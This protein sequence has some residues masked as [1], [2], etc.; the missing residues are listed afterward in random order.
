MELNSIAH[1][2]YE[3]LSKS[4]RSAQDHG[5]LPN[6]V[7]PP[8][9]LLELESDRTVRLVSGLTE[10]LVAKNVITKAELDELLNGIIP[11]KQQKV[12]PSPGPSSS[13]PPGPW[14]GKD[15]FE[16]GQYDWKRVE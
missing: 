9:K 13:L 3:K 2:T 1:R 14:P 10:A 6:T 11:Q 8:E 5:W 4:H 15:A 7:P 12:S 16:Q